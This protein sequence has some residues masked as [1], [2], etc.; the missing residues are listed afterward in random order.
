MVV[1]IIFAGAGDERWL[2]LR[3]NAPRVNSQAAYYNG[4]PDNRKLANNAVVRRWVQPGAA[5]QTVRTDFRHTAFLL[6]IKC[7]RQVAQSQ[8]I[9]FQLAEANDYRNLH[10]TFGCNR[11]FQ[12][13]EICDA[14]VAKGPPFFK[15][16][17]YGS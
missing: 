16:C 10:F 4:W 5:A 8:D 13:R 1:S 7:W 3:S 2:I 9:S 14:E 6:F 15:P 11:R 17:H 12:P